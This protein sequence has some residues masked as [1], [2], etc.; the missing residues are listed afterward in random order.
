[1]TSTDERANGKPP[2]AVGAEKPQYPRRSGH[3]AFKLHRLMVRM[4]VAQEI[5]PVAAF[6]VD[7]IAFQEDALHYSRPVD[8]YNESLMEYLGLASRSSLVRARNKAVKAGWL[9]YEQGAKS[10]PGRYWVTTPPGVESL[11][12]VPVCET[13]APECRSDSVRQTEPEAPAS[14]TDSQQK[15]DG[16]RAPFDPVPE[17]KTSMG[18]GSEEQTG[19]SHGEGERGSQTTPTPPHAHSPTRP[20]GGGPLNHLRTAEQ[21]AD[22]GLLVRLHRTLACDPDSPV[23]GSEQDLLRLVTLSEHCLGR[24]QVKRPVAVFVARV[25]RGD[26]EK[27]TQAEEDRAAERLIEWRRAANGQPAGI[28]KPAIVRQTVLSLS[29]RMGITTAD[30]EQTIAETD[31]RRE[32]ALQM[33][34]RSVRQGTFRADSAVSAS[35]TLPLPHSSDR[36]NIA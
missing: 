6:L 34:R 13:A 12:D 17:E 8:F 19:G 33:L 22:T 28:E 32:M 16:K 30:P 29:E 15:R 7:L 4:R 25:Q 26:W 14:R 1:M 21:L 3:F 10:V 36:R 2:D 35:P 24:K 20:R 18:D 5:G 31:R 11:D 23:T 9:H 27:F